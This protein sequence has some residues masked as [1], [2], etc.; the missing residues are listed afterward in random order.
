MRACSCHE[1]VKLYPL[2][3][4]RLRELGHPDGYFNDRLVEAIDDLLAAPSSRAARAG[5]AEGAVPV[6]DPAFEGRSA[7]QKFLMRLAETTPRRSR[8]AA[9]DS[10]RLTA[11]HLK[12]SDERRLMRGESRS[13]PDRYGH[14]TKLRPVCQ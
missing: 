5:A 13:C 8:Q 7:G 11:R 2:F 1:Y 10:A 12:T 3:P 14:A 9:R 4:E 6:R